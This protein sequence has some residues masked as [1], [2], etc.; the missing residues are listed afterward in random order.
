MLKSC[1]LLIQNFN[2]FVIKDKLK[3]RLIELVVKKKKKIDKYRKLNNDS[4]GM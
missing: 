4:L 2:S 1:I 3:N